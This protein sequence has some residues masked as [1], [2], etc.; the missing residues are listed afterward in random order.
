MLSTTELLVQ[1]QCEDSG[2]ASIKPASGGTA[3]AGKMKPVEND[4][5]WCLVSFDREKFHFAQATLYTLEFTPGEGGTAKT[6]TIPIDTAPTLEW[7]KSS[8]GG[9]Q[10]RSNI[11]FALDGK[12]ALYQSGDP[13]PGKT[14]Q[15]FTD[16]VFVY[17][18]MEI[19]ISLSR[20][21]L[22]PVDRSDRNEG[23]NPRAIGKIHGELHQVDVKQTTKSTGWK[24]PEEKISGLSDV[25]GD[26]LKV[27]KAPELSA[28][29]PP[30]SKD[31]AWLW[32]N[33]TVTAGSGTAPA[34]ILDGK[35]APWTTLVGTTKWT[36]VEVDANVGNNKVNGK[37]AQDVI[38]FMGPFPT[39]YTEWGV[40]GLRISASPTYETNRALNHKN[41]LGAEDVVW[42]FNQLNQTVAVKNARKAM[43]KGDMNDMPKAGDWENGAVWGESFHIH[44]GFEG[45]GALASTVV[46][47][48]KTKATVGTIPTYSI[49][50]FVPGLDGTFQYRGFTVESDITGRYLCTTEHTSL[51]DKNGNPY[52]QTV[53]GWKAVN[54]LTTTWAPGSSPNV[55][56]TV[57][58]TNGFS[59]PTYQRANGVKIGVAVAY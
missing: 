25:L 37:S 43:E 11:A 6:I 24:K 28:A 55:K 22:C 51:S 8:A 31:G 34:W 36:W 56:F 35:L 47:N 40:A 4:H 33:G 19:E 17:P 48:S 45:G 15:Q 58:Y 49:A 9:V 54:V 7:Q 41:F 46:T 52:L 2:R 38:D 27:P 3:A 59:A 57:T 16:A 44:S 32:I 42:D 23:L 18:D 13:C 53:S 50:R 14:D 20:T 21:P 29:K 5:D 30:T 12:T 39:Y 26:R 1:H 10:L